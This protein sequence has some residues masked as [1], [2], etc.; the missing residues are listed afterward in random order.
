MKYSRQDICPLDTAILT[1]DRVQS[2]RECGNCPL[3][4]AI[5]THDTTKSEIEWDICPLHTAILTQDRVE[6]NRMGLLLYM[7]GNDEKEHCSGW[8]GMGI[9]A[10]YTAHL[11]NVLLLIVLYLNSDSF[12]FL[13]SSLQPLF[14][15]QRHGFLR[16][17]SSW[18][19][20]S[21]QASFN[22]L[23]L[24][25][26]PQEFILYCFYILPFLFMFIP[27]YPA[28]L[29]PPHSPHYIFPGYAVTRVLTLVIFP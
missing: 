25:T 9:S 11:I 26:S 29:P 4:T 15:L 21:V 10:L 23:I 7:H 28:S 6:T 2:E 22:L 19:A 8:D 13:R 18:L 14:H 12:N 27:S 5:F 3:H 17:I 1:Q 20:F 16:A 24:I